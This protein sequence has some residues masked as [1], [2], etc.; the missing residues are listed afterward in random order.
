LLPHQ[1]RNTHENHEESGNRPKRP[2]V[3]TRPSKGTHHKAHKAKPD[4]LLGNF[5]RW[6]VLTPPCRGG[7]PVLPLAWAR[8]VTDLRHVITGGCKSG[9]GGVTY[10]R[11]QPAE[12]R[13]RLIGR[14]TFEWRMPL[15]N[16]FPCSYHL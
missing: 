3:R 5:T 9:R 4:V 15:T 10:H 2:V 8:Q 1:Q 11:F 14:H 16:R 6:L 13:A 7:A 12:D